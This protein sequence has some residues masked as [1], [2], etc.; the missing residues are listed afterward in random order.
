[1]PR[2]SSLGSPQPLCPDLS[3]CEGD[4]L[5]GRY[6]IESLR[7]TR[8][9]GANFEA[10]D[11]TSGA[12]VSI[13]VLVAPPNSFGRP[14]EDHARVWF[15][16]GARRAK[17]LSSPH[18]A[19]VLDAGVTLEGH[20]WI[21]R[22]HLGGSPLATH[23]KYDAAISTKEAVDI[24]LAI[25]DAMAEAHA[26]GIV[27]GS[28]GPHAVHVAWSAS[29]LA[30]VKV[31]G[32][33]TAAAENALA[34]GSSKDAECVLRAPEQ[35]TDGAIVDARADVWAIGVLLHTMLA[36]APPFSADTPSGASLSVILDDPPSLAGVP[37]DLGELVDRTLSKN[38]AHRPGSVLDLA[39]ELVGFSSHPTFAKERIDARRPLAS[40][41][42]PLADESNPMLRM[43]KD[44][45]ELAMSQS[46]GLAVP[47][48]DPTERRP[49]WGL[50]HEAKPRAPSGWIAPHGHDDEPSPSVRDLSTIHPQVE[51]SLRRFATTV[52]T[53]KPKPTFPRRR[54]VQ[55]LGA[56]TAAASMALLIVIGTEGA[57]VMRAR[58]AI[59][60]AAAAP[61][62]PVVTSETT[63]T[64]AELTPSTI[65]P[66]ETIE[67][68][69]TPSATLAPPAKAAPKRAR[70]LASS[71]APSASGD[72]LRRFLDDRR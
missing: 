72:D 1:M 13:H 45:H 39:E 44:A 38:P 6:R 48:P 29:G 23:L 53:R 65:A 31:V 10:T 4:L 7:V 9:G 64:A 14:N 42:I 19:R 70:P 34:L 32:A 46:R 55:V 17:A 18:V 68:P 59:V 12:R 60:A 41:L 2:S 69:A 66:P 35:L 47:A 22:E 37:D 5:G 11:L 71:P 63:T 51:P 3:L 16:A 50:L 24:A 27:H 30:D 49:T 25:C 28:L 52:L 58:R 54:A 61:A 62:A 15:L 33:G 36:G 21:V 26:N 43:V 20:P 40:S 67:L 57:K 56:L 8:V